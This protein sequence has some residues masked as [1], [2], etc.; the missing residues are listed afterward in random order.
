PFL[1]YG[2]SRAAGRSPPTDSGGPR[3]GGTGDP[4]DS[5]LLSASART[6]RT[7][8][9]HLA[10]PLAARVAAARNQKPGLSQRIFARELHRRVQSAFCRGT[11]TS[12]PRVSAGTRKKSRSDLLSAARADGEQRQHRAPGL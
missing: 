1:P 5:G 9:W 7:Q 6:R 11:N 4:D 2:E 12:G 8:L 10:R 3:S